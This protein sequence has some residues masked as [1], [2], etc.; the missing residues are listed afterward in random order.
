MSAGSKREKKLQQTRVAYR[1]ATVSE[2][3]GVQVNTMIST[4]LQT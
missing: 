4:Q 2:E 3:E 1:V